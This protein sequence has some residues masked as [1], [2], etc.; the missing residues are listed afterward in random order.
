MP[1]VVWVYNPKGEQ[2]EAGGIL[3]LTVQPAELDGEFQ[4][5]GETPT[6]TKRNR[7]HKTPDVSL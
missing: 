2:V 1:V 4:V 5:Q 6:Q 3:E 7:R